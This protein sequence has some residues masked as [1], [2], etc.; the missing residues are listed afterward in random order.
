[1][2][3]TRVDDL[4]KE[5]GIPPKQVMGMLE[6]LEIFVHSHL[7][8][9][10]PE[11]VASMRSHRESCKREE[12]RRAE[13]AQARLE[14][15]KSRRNP[16]QGQHLDPSTLC[17]PEPWGILLEGKPGARAERIAD[18]LGIPW[19]VLEDFAS[20]VGRMKM[21]GGTPFPVY[22]PELA[23]TL[24]GSPVFVEARKKYSERQ[25]R[26]AAKLKA[27]SRRER[28]VGCLCN[29]H[30]DLVDV[31]RAALETVWQGVSEEDLLNDERYRH[32]PVRFW[33]ALAPRPDPDCEANAMDV[34][35]N[36]IQTMEHPRKWKVNSLGDQDQPLA[37][38]IWNDGR[39]I[40]EAVD[41]YRNV[42]LAAIRHV[43]YAD[44]AEKKSDRQAQ[45]RRRRQ[46]A[47]E[48]LR[49][50]STRTCW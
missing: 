25:G 42:L 23:R 24:P 46:D 9:L 28:L 50:I 12:K 5:F 8:P 38:R 1:M 7:S 49:R 45:K 27:E 2:N 44:L 34:I 18:R 10:K 48:H 33:D 41:D 35:A 37:W 20:P 36:V 19:P 16:I 17:P 4:A 14:Y 6:E 22:D 40:D 15:K 43:W 32:L 47:L 13:L 30:R 3:T 29:D 21:P 31:Y 11:Q 26:S 39:G